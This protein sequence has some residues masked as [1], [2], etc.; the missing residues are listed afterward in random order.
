MSL[1][2][3]IKKIK[4]KK[5]API[6][7]LKGDQTLLI[8]NFLE[9]LKQSIFATEDEAFNYIRFDMEETL[10]QDAIAEAQSVPFFGDSKLVVIDNPYF[11]TA[12]RKNKELEHNLEMLLRYF[13]A[14]S[15][16]TVLVFLH[17]YEKFD[18][19][20]KIVK[21]LKKN[22]IILSVASLSERETREYV[23]SHLEQQGVDLA[24][25]AYA[26]LAYLCDLDL[27][28]MMNELEKLSL[29]AE[30]TQ[31]I[32]KQN[33]KDL[34]PKSLDHNIFDMTNYVMR[35]EKEAALRL[36]QDLLKQGE[37]TIKINA[38]LMSQVR[39]FLQVKL[40]L[41]IQ[42]QQSNIVDVLKVHPYR[43]KLAVQEVR[44]ISLEK[45]G[46]VFD[47]LVEN[48]YRFKTGQMERNLLFE[49]FILK[50]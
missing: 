49:L 11:L 45:L 50:V 7:V 31:K 6:Y 4:E 46:L 34:V 43:V 18:E 32:T 38:I 5:I 40:L 26:E 13:E 28:R 21:S 37:D 17:S 12:E 10:I 3:E 16:Q 41:S 36:Y 20:K 1:Q 48:D 30:D 8:Q 2:K 35:G 27:S 23:M 39:L 9:E 47:E 42:Y 33:V 44:P 15:E 25:E 29:F 24:Q 19:R 14:P 22:S